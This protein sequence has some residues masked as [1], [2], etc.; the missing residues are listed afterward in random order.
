MRYWAIAPWFSEDP[1]DWQK[2]WSYDL[3]HDVI[4]AGWSQAG[5]VSQLTTREAIRRRLGR[6]ASDAGVG[7]LWAFYQTVRPRDIVVARKGRKMI[8]AVGTVTRRGFY[9][10]GRARRV[11][12]DPAFPNFL[13]VKWHAR[14][15]NKELRHAE[16]GQQTVHEIDAAKYR[17]LVGTFQPEDD[18]DVF[19]EGRELFRQHRSLERNQRLV[20][21]AKRRR[22][23]RDP[24]LRCQVCGFSFAEVYGDVGEGFIEAHHT[25]P[26]A[27]KKSPAGT[28]VEDL[29]LVCSNCHRILHRWKAR[30]GLEGLRR[31]LTKRSG[32]RQLRQT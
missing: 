18:R 1:G 25:R 3:R 16:F 23:E 7:A 17:R 2:M 19:P 10:P 5:D 8:A 22:R 14:P 9:D 12:L 21:C 11:G 6:D 24:L 29:A 15:R 27:K 30:P 26:L 4:S 13:G 20:E 31:V 32:A 28:R